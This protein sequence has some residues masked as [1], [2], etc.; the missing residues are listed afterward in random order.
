MYWP[1]SRFMPIARPWR[2]IVLLRWET[3]TFW[4]TP[5]DWRA[6]RADS[7]PKHSV[8]PP[9]WSEGA[10]RTDTGCFAHGGVA[11]IISPARACPQPSR[12][13][14]SA[15]G[16]SGPKPEAEAYISFG[17]IPLSVS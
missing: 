10:P 11:D 2:N 3:S 6:S 5:C 15:S 13:G 7:M 17:L 8:M 16:P 9:I 4:P 12:D 14:N 1:D